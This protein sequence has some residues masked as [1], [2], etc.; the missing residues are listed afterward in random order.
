MELTLKVHRYDPATDGKGQLQTYTLD[1]DDD[2]SVL[3]ALI[4]ERRSSR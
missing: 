2:A 1:I 3:D 4:E